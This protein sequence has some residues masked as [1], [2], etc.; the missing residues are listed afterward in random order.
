MKRF[1]L[2][3]FEA[4]P[5]LLGGILFYA[6]LFRPSKENVTPKKNRNV[7]VRKMVLRETE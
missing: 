2:P 4:E 1:F 7:S 6:A 3:R 5:K